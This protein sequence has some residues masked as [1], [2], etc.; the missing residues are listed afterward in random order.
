MV[1]TKWRT[2]EKVRV[3]IHSDNTCWCSN[4]YILG[5]SGK[6]IRSP[7]TNLRYDAIPWRFG[8][9][10][11][12]TESTRH[13]LGL[14]VDLMGYF[15]EARCLRAIPWRGSWV[16]SRGCDRCWTI[17]REVKLTRRNACPVRKRRSTAAY[18]TQEKDCI[19]LRFAPR[20]WTPTRNWLLEYRALAYCRAL[21]NWRGA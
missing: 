21:A 6:Q 12:R 2:S 3:R 1:W 15:A 18:W 9:H 14:K 13:A 20:L 17:D 19:H 10:W 5:Q 7:P 8:L 4:W 11:R 16:A